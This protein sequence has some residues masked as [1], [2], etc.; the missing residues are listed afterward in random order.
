MSVSDFAELTRG[1]PERSLVTGRV[2]KSGGRNSLGR[3][4]VMPRLTGLPISVPMPAPKKFAIADT[5]GSVLVLTSN[6]VK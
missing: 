4:T 1:A 2:N 6:M 5:R 3:V